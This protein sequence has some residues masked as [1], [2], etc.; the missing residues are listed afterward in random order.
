MLKGKGREGQD[1]LPRG[2]RAVATSGNWSS[3]IEVTRSNCS[4]TAVASGWAKILRTA[5]A[6]ISALAPRPRPAHLQKPYVAHL[7]G[8]HIEQTF[9]QCRQLLTFR[10]LDGTSA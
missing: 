9:Q 1:V 7:P 2:P 8:F 6:T 10:S 3:S 4:S 5:A